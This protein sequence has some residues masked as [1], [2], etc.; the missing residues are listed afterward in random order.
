[1]SLRLM[2]RCLAAVTLGLWWLAAGSPA[3]AADSG[4]DG[5][6]LKKVKAATIRLEV[7]LPNGDVVEGS[8]FFTDEPGVIL[9]NAH[10]LGMLSADSRFPQKVTVVVNSGETDSREVG[11]KFMSVDRG[12]DLAVLRVDGKDLPESLK[13]SRST[14]RRFPAFAKTT[15]A[16][17]IASKST[18]A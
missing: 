18:A 9:T 10:V 11:V 5:A 1:M 14:N 16:Y 8:G 7:T 15:P 12:S 4:L 13:K 2:L 3:N 6:V 17:W